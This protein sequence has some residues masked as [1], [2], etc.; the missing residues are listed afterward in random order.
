MTTRV[1]CQSVGIDAQGKKC[2]WFDMATL[3]C[4]WDAEAKSQPHCIYEIDMGVNQENLAQVEH[5]GVPDWLTQKIE[6]VRAGAER[7]RHLWAE[8]MYQEIH[9]ALDI[10][11][12]YRPG[13]PVYNAA[14]LGYL[15]GI[16]MDIVH[17]HAIGMRISTMLG[18]ARAMAN[19]LE[20]QR[21]LMKNRKLKAIRDSYAVGYRRG[22]IT[23]GAMD[24]DVHNDPEYA[25]MLEDTAKAKEQSETLEMHYKG[26]VELVN[27]LKYQITTLQEEKK[28]GG[29]QSG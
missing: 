11:D 20:V 6:M 1:N 12:K 27:A 19:T 3:S 22:K 5:V 4:T 2:G 24:I 17:I 13:S 18:E 7:L 15:P 28:Y 26:L 8:E 23:Q 10:S 21:K 9:R 29:R 14:N 25:T 16:N